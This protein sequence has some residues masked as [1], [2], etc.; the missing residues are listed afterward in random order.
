MSDLTRHDIE[1]GV[2]GALDSFLFKAALAAVVGAIVFGVIRFDRGYDSTDRMTES[3]T[4]ES[5]MYLRIDAMTGCHYLEGTNGGITPRLDAEG[6]H[7]CDGYSAKIDGAIL[8][9]E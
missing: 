1:E 8:N 4:T 2:R 5:G 6:D 3:D 7:V 9:A